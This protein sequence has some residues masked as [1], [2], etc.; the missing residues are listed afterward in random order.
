MK[1]TKQL[2]GAVLVLM[3]LVIFFAA[4]INS[5]TV[6]E[7]KQAEIAFFQSIENKINDLSP[8]EMI[9]TLDSLLSLPKIHPKVLAI[10]NQ[11]IKRDFNNYR[12]D[13]NAYP[14]HKYYRSWDTKKSHPYPEKLSK[15]DKTLVLNLTENDNCGY[16]QPIKGEITSRYGWRDKKM[17]NGIDLNLRTGDTVRAAFSGRVRLSRWQNGYGKAIVIRHYNGLETVYGHLSKQ[18]VKSG[19]FVEAGTPIGRGGNTGRSRGSHLHLET[20]FKGKP[21][22]PEI[23]IDFRNGVLKNDTLILKKNRKGYAGYLPET[24]IRKIRQNRHRIASVYEK[25]IPLKS[26]FVQ[27]KAIAVN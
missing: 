11:K 16:Y 3:V 4:K 22:N 1:F 12:A 24:Y 18:L 19:D 23:F 26:E 17:H 13:N 21:I 20:R 25:R 15:N 10:V 5:D 14:A 6:T 2:L 8:M 9:S 27:S 7:K